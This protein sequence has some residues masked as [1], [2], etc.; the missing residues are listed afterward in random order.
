MESFSHDRR[1]CHG[2]LFPSFRF[3]LRP[4][5]TFPPCQ[6]LRKGL[7]DFYPLFL[8]FSSPIVAPVKGELLHIQHYSFRLGLRIRPKTWSMP[9]ALPLGCMCPWEQRIL[10]EYLLL[11]LFDLSSVFEGSVHP[12]FYVCT[13]VAVNLTDLIPLVC[14]C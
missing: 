2:F 12:Y 6:Y 8:W 5:P 14:S 3:C 10:M 13:C 4:L 7:G 1:S 9:S 11:S